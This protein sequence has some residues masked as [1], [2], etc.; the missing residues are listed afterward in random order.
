MFLVQNVCSVFL[1]VDMKIVFFTNVFIE[2]LFWWRRAFF[3]FNENGSCTILITWR[4]WFSRDNDALLWRRHH[5][6]VILKIILWAV[7][8][9]SQ[10]IILE[11]HEVVTYNVGK[12]DTLPSWTFWTVN[13]ILYNL[14]VQMI[15]K[16]YIILMF[17]SRDAQVETD[18]Q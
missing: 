18:C 5:S 3:Y 4:I 9:S 13:Q 6:E 7:K 11:I 14:S 8:S 2:Q 17:C 16:Q 10:R 15:R 12:N 1:M